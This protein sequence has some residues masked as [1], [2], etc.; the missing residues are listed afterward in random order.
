MKSAIQPLSAT[1]PAMRATPM[2][3]GHFRRF[4]GDERH[5]AFRHHFHKE[6]AAVKAKA[7]GAAEGHFFVFHV[8]TKCP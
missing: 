3:P 5:E 8:R 7:E 4:A 2:G 6:D 1:V